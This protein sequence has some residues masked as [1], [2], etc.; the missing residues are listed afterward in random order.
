M[1]QRGFILHCCLS[2]G[3]VL[4]I[5]HIFKDTLLHPTEQG[6]LRDG[7]VVTP[8]HPPTRPPQQTFLIELQTCPHPE[9]LKG[10]SLFLPLILQAAPSTSG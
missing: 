10:F 6:Q 5:Q 4:R 3:I 1:S 2:P 8:H 9:P 7:Q